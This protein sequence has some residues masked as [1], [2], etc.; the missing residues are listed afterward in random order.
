MD[1]VKTRIEQLKKR[2][3]QH[4]KTIELELLRRKINKISEQTGIDKNKLNRRIEIGYKLDTLQL[5]FEK[6]SEKLIKKYTETYNGYI[7]K[8][9]N[10]T[11]RMPQYNEGYIE[12]FLKTTQKKPMKWEGYINEIVKKIANIPTKKDIYAIRMNRYLTEIISS[13]RSKVQYIDNTYN[14]KHHINDAILITQKQLCCSDNHHHYPNERSSAP[15][16]FDTN[17]YYDAHVRKMASFHANAE[18][19]FPEIGYLTDEILMTEQE[20][21]TKKNRLIKNLLKEKKEIVELDKADSYS[22]V[23]YFGDEFLK[24]KEFNDNLKK[25][26]VEIIEKK[27]ILKS[28]PSGAKKDELLNKILSLCSEQ[29]NLKQQIAEKEKDIKKLIIRDK[30]NKHTIASITSEQYKQCEQ[31]MASYISAFK[32]DGSSSSDHLASSSDNTGLIQNGRVQQIIGL[33]I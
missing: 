28:T 20:F 2:V 1:L 8:I 14:I 3:N 7:E 13:Y 4:K 27:E 11:Q 12:G 32:E 19:Y 18:V 16:N 25:I 33:D 5:K 21:D 22:G 31:I 26:G 17:K 10:I 30:F 15:F 29:R 9:T 24:Y 6:K 23:D